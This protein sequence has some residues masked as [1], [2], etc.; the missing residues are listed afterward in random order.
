MRPERWTLQ[1]VY[2]VGFLSFIA[3]VWALWELLDLYH[4]PLFGWGG[5]YSACLIAP[6]VAYVSLIHPRLNNIYEDDG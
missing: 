1:Q 5:I 2:W 3:Q 6:T 4:M